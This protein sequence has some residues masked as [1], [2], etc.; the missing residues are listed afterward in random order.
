MTLTVRTMD[1]SDSSWEGSKIG[2]E[3]RESTLTA[4]LKRP[5]DDCDK[6]ARHGGIARCC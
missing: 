4:G 2:F 5:K 1:K 6:Y 3:A